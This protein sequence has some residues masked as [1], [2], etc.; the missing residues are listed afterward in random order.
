MHTRRG[1]TAKTSQGLTT[2]VRTTG[3]STRR[4]VWNGRTE[5]EFQIK[6]LWTE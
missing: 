2:H 3:A 4:Q 5:H 6:K 1:T